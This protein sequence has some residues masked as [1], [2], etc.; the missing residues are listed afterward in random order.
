MSEKLKNMGT[1]IQYLFIGVTYVLILCIYA[2]L[3][4]TL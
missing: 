2:F 4:I 3:S 1:S